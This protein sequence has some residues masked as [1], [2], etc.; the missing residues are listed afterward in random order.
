GNWDDIDGAIW[1][2]ALAGRKTTF[3]VQESIG[4]SVLP[5]VGTEN[6]ARTT[7]VVQIGAVLEAIDG[8]GT[9]TEANDASALTQFEVKQTSDLDVHG[10]AARDTPAG[11]AA[12]DQIRAFIASVFAGKSHI[13]VPPGCTGGSCDFSK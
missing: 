2:E 3:L 8:I 13:T 12:R 5:N 4:D 6:V 9:A 11:L 7:G 1:K 10:F